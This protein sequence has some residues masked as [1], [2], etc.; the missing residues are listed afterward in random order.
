MKLSCNCLATGERVDFNNFATWKKPPPK[1]LGAYIVRCF[2]FQ[3]RH[4]R[5]INREDVYPYI[6][7]W[8]Q[9]GKTNQTKLG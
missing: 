1:R 3:T 6:T 9:E 8:D 5:T 7:I 4:I 2:I